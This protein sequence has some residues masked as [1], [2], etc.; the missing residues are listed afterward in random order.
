MHIDGAWYY[1]HTPAFSSDRADDKISELAGNDETDNGCKDQVINNIPF[2]LSNDIDKMKKY[3]SRRNPEKRLDF[4]HQII[5]GLRKCRKPG[6]K[7]QRLPSCN[8]QN[9]Q[10][11]VYAEFLL[12]AVGC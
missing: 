8:N 5:V 9:K 7:I 1:K 6:Y 11:V 12:F 4:H 10:T 3:K 2:F